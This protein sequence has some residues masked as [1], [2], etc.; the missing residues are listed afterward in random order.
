MCRTQL[1]GKCV[2]IGFWFFFSIICCLSTR[3]SCFQNGFNQQIRP[4]R[5]A[6]L[7]CPDKFT[8]VTLN[9]VWCRCLAC[10]PSA[11]HEVVESLCQQPPNRL[12]T[13]V[14]VLANVWYHAGMSA[15][16]NETNDKISSEI[17]CNCIR[18]S[19]YLPH[20]V[21]T[22][23]IYH[24]WGASPLVWDRRFGCQLRVASAYRRVWLHRPST[25]NT[26]LWS[27]PQMTLIRVRC[28]YPHTSL[29]HLMEEKLFEISKERTVSWNYFC[30]IE[31]WQ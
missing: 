11:N 22:N 3:C 15:I 19:V 6:K 8:S 30:E 26:L 17:N 29:H 28:R 20:S 14:H 21:A 23:P 1:Y 18:T 9:V 13:I 31:Q 4:C 10:I 27:P 16:T 7:C 25:M 5:C 24:I 12:V 2:E